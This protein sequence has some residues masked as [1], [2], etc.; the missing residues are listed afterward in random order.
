M[1]HLEVLDL[2]HNSFLTDEGLAHV[3]DAVEH[4]A[5]PHL[6]SINL[7]DSNIEPTRI[8]FLVH[9]LTSGSLGHLQ[10]L[11]LTGTK[12]GDGPTRG[13]LQTLAGFCPDIRRI[14]LTNC[15]K[16]VSSQALAA[17]HEALAA[18]AWPNL[19]EIKLCYDDEEMAGDLLSTLAVTGVGTSLR[20]VDLQWRFHEGVM[21]QRL[22]DIF[23]QGACPAL[24][25]FSFH[26]RS[27][28][29]ND[30]PGGSELS[31]RLKGSLAGRARVHTYYRV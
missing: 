11:D 8:A 2:G 28:Y 17:F 18:R 22:V 10:Y 12:I 7:Q 1:P 5:C 23:Y 31:K 3:M 20:H 4:K 14:D 19:E 6:K 24:R 15:Y 16:G 21:V 29:L 30:D 13:I 9:A 25:L 26:T 27:L